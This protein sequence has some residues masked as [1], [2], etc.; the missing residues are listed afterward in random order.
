MSQ[1]IAIEP[2]VAGAVFENFNT[3]VRAVGDV[4]IVSAVGKIMVAKGVG[5][6]GAVVVGEIVSALF[7]CEKCT[8]REHFF[9]CNV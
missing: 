9:R 4:V 2:F 3:V 6:G 7:G 5:K 1:R 8:F